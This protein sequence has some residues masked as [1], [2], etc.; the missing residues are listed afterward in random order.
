MVI[1][2]KVLDLGRERKCMKKNKI[3]LQLIVALLMVL[4]TFRSV[5]RIIDVFMGQGE[6]TIIFNTES[7]LDPEILENFILDHTRFN[8]KEIEVEISDDNVRIVLPY[9]TLE[10][11]EK[12]QDQVRSLIDRKIHGES[13][14]VLEAT[15]WKD[16]DAFFYII[17]G[18]YIFIFI[19][20]FILFMI[21]IRNLIK[22]YTYS[23]E[24]VGKYV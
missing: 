22:A 1:N 19:G 21:S 17:F 7:D 2:D 13:V 14:A 4:L 20:G 23:D 15:E 10:E 16:L 3:Y 8:E 12:I 11:G 6:S 5:I 24:K 9:M 18:L